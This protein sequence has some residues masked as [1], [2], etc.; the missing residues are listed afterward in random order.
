MSTK[1]SLDYQDQFGLE[2]RAQLAYSPTCPAVYVKKFIKS[3]IELNGH[4]YS[5]Y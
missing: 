4:V 1:R 5:K 3:V 2:I